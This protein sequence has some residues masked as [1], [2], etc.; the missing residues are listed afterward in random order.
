[1]AKPDKPIIIDGV[2]VDLTADAFDDF[3]IVECLADIVDDASEPSAKLAATV[4][5]YRLLFGADFERVK[6][7]LRAK[8]DGKLT[9]EIMGD[10]LNACMAEVQAKN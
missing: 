1:M 4:R 7:E 8:H 5:I 10:F 3:E 9:N 6:R 2:K